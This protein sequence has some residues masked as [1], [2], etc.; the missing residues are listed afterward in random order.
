MPVCDQT[1]F[2]TTFAN[3]SYLREQTV[4][5]V[6]CSPCSSYTVEPLHSFYTVTNINFL[7]FDF[8]SHASSRVRQH[9]H[10]F[11]IFIRKLSFI[12][13]SIGDGTTAAKAQLSSLAADMDKLR[14]LVCSL[15][16]RLYHSDKQQHLPGC[17]DS[18]VSAPPGVPH[19]ST[20]T[21]S[22]RP[23]II[24]PP[25]ISTAAAAPSALKICKRPGCGRHLSTPSADNDP[26]LLRMRLAGLW[27]DRKVCTVCKSHDKAV[28]SSRS[29][30][31]SSTNKPNLTA[32]SSPRH[33][34]PLPK[35]F[36]DDDTVSFRT[37][38]TI[39]RAPAFPLQRTNKIV[40]ADTLVG[41]SQFVMVHC[42]LRDGTSCDIHFFRLTDGRGWVHSYDD[43]LL[44]PGSHYDSS[45]SPPSR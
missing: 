20:T 9:I 25:F 12:S 36:P 30:P 22:P 32:S 10:G 17:G 15:E 28:A 2:A 23:S 14:L 7:I 41:F 42:P 40:K 24:P 13:P 21:S 27:S 31:P 5:H 19:I 38:R 4:H 34:S 35:N 16:E 3:K 45:S 39:L 33:L 11:A 1:L 26:Y 44:A 37:N 8:V 29:L 43:N 18:I 6:A